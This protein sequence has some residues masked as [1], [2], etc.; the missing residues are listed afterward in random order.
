MRSPN[1]FLFGDVTVRSLGTIEIAFDTFSLQRYLSV[2]M[3]I[4][5][6]VVPS[7]RGID[8]LD[9]EKLY[10]ENATN[11]IVRYKVLSE[12]WKPLKYED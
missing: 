11:Q 6:V 9:S 8:G 3:D 7:L 12:P 1:L 10:A 4:V 2:V 5:P